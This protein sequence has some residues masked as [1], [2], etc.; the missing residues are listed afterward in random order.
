MDLL[1]TTFADRGHGHGSALLT[2][3]EQF[4]SSKAR[5]KKLIAIATADEKQAISV[6]QSKFDFSKLNGRQTRL[7]IGEFP[8]LQYYE[9]SVL[10]SKDLSSE[11][12]AA[13][14]KKK[15]PGRPK[16]QQPGEG[17]APKA[18]GA[19]T[20]AAAA[21]GAAPAAG[22]AGGEQKKWWPFW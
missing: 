18:D 19:L 11:A 13:A 21:G 10:L 14:L 4:L 6:M 22:Q 16:K 9:R 15:R 12:R 7:M 8:P 1:T 20:P 17:D 3:A 5:V 2:A